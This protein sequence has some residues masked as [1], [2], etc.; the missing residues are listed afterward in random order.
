MVDLIDKKYE[1][2]SYIGGQWYKGINKRDVNN[3]SN[4]NEIV[5]QI[6]YAD[7]AL[8]LQAG[9]AAK[10]AGKEW[11]RMPSSKRGNY[12]Y[13]LS[14]VLKDNIEELATLASREMGK[15]IKEMK[16]E[17]QRAVDLFK[18]YA[19]EGVRSNGDVIPASDTGVLQYSMK[20]PLGVVGIIT[21]WNFPVAIPIW[22]IAPAL[23]CGNSV[24]WKPADQAVLTA[25]RMIE[26]FEK[27]GL[28]SGV[29]NLVVGKGR[30]VGSTLLEEVN[31]NGLSFTGSTET[32]QYIASVCASRNIKY[33][34]EMG[35][36]NAAVIL[37]DAD[38]NETIPI[39][40]SG[41]FRSSGQK[42]TATSRIIVE[43]S[44]YEEFMEKLITEADKLEMSSA[45]NADAFLGP[46]ASQEQFDKINEYIKLADKEAT[47]L[48]KRRAGTEN[49]YY[50]P[51]VI[52]EGVS[53][54]HALV[55]EEIF[56]P[57]ATV[58]TAENFEEAI[59]L[60]NNTV[61]GLSASIFTKD[62]SKGHRFL[63]EAEVGLVRVNQETAGVE[64]QSPFG[65]TKSS[66][67]HS[68]EQGQAALDFYSQLKTCAIKHTF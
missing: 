61:F 55:Q 13:S 42:C 25:T 35:G 39:I 19:G 51:P 12:L 14:D 32:G 66:S 38:L 48:T 63:E 40:L 20:V 50:I 5:G 36:K 23:I 56:G 24:I 54:S 45:L 29:L 59:D 49:G 60:C 43:R 2:Q 58:L 67:S 31:L 64:Y 47:I 10:K 27:S 46:V 9:E 18:Y 17:V 65:G 15:P 68:S 62:L 28:P 6:H 11:S 4:L 22:K 33:Q 37:K 41:A 8:T 30:D 34:T 16:G 44:I 21:P 57:L 3:P 53:V 1:A 7:S 26:L 52:V